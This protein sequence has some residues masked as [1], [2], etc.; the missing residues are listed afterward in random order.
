MVSVQT[1]GTIEFAIVENPY[2]HIQNTKFS[3]RKKVRFTEFNLG[4]DKFNDSNLIIK[5]PQWRR[6]EV[7]HHLIKQ[8]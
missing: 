5:D 3:N 8:F 4:I 2:A 1:D 7:E 6:I